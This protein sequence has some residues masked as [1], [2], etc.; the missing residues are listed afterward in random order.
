MVDA[1]PV[2]GEVM[3][4]I[5]PLGTGGGGTASGVAVPTGGVPVALVGAE[6]VVEAVSGVEEEVGGGLTGAIFFD[7]KSWRSCVFV[8]QTSSKHSSFVVVRSPSALIR[9]A[10]SLIAFT[11][12]ARIGLSESERKPFLFTPTASGINC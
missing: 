3:G 9:A 10:N 6:G 5:S 2:N 8:I 7:S 12:A 11:R 1:S 4:N